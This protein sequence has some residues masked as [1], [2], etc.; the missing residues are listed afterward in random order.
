MTNDLFS[1]PDAKPKPCLLRCCRCQAGH[2]FSLIEVLLVVAMVAILAMVGAPIY[3]SLQVSNELDVATNTLVQDLYR[4]QSL[5]RNVASDDSW[6][7]AVNGHTI[8]LFRGANFASRA[9]GAD[10]NYQ[11]PSSVTIS[12]INQ[13]TY[14]KLSGLPGS[15]GSFTLSGGG[16]SRSV[17][18]NSKGMVEY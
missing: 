4:A 15:T 8:T 6:G 1:A 17:T 14:T 10:E 9:G 5:S 13:I 2:G 3:Q 18:V 12:G 7:V 16:K 11:V